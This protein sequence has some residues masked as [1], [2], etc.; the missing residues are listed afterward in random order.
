[1]AQ[2]DHGRRLD[3]ATRLSHGATLHLHAAHRPQLDLSLGWATEAAVDVSVAGGGTR[4]QREYLPQGSSDTHRK[5]ELATA[6][7][8]LG[9]RA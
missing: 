4:P 9:L 5:K 6:R 3:S 7:G 8:S 2:L 1:M